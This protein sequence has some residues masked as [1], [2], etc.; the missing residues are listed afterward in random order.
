MD[1]ANGGDRLDPDRMSFL[2]LP[3]ELR[4]QVYELALV[5]PCSCLPIVARL[6][7]YQL[8]ER[9]WWIRESTK[10]ELH[11]LM[12]RRP[13]RDRSAWVP[14]KRYSG[15]PIR[16]ESGDDSLSDIKF[17]PTQCSYELHTNTNVSSSLLMVNKQVYSEAADIFYGRNVFAFNVP[18]ESAC[19]APLSFL[20]DLGDAFTMIRSLHLWLNLPIPEKYTD[21]YPA[22]HPPSNYHWK[23]LIGVLRQLQ[24]HHLGLT[25]HGPILQ[26]TSWSVNTLNFEFWTK[27]LI[28][29]QQVDSVFLAVHCAPRKHALVPVIPTITNAFKFNEALKNALL[30]DPN[31]YGGSTKVYKIKTSSG[32][33]PHFAVIF[34]KVPRETAGC[35]GVDIVGDQFVH[36]AAEEGTLWP[37][38]DEESGREVV[39]ITDW[40]SKPGLINSHTFW[41]S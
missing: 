10:K 18:W 19:F 29:L 17:I 8:L 7:K 22:G 30:K 27:E 3:P 4:N 25:F 13:V 1:N 40:R 20:N 26:W 5:S 31:N 39:D 16:D 9:P 38:T 11:S 2:D 37:V 6:S 35:E 12:L 24:L 32:H 34:G 23:N 21:S 14:S 33:S 15:T 28:K 36:L 41:E